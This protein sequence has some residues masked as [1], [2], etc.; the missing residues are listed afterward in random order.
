MKKFIS[1]ILLLSGLVIWAEPAVAQHYGHHGYR[2]YH[3]NYYRGGNS[4]GWIAPAIIGGAVVYGMTR[5]S[6][7][8]PPPVLI[9][10]PNQMV[11]P[12]ASPQGFHWEQILDYN[13]N[14]YRTV[15]V[16]N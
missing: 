3:N 1:I 5:P 6:V 14:C 9:Q 16:P 11:V 2:G 10:Q 4:W 8:Q 7:V 12:Y 15:L 13:C